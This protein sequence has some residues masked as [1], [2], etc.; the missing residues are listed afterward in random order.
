MK[1]VEDVHLPVDLTNNSLSA[2]KIQQFSILR[3]ISVINTKIFRTTPNVKVI[4][5]AICEN[6]LP[7]SPRQGSTIPHIQYMS[8]SFWHFF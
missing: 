5:N 2:F 4:L 7:K 1:A 8:T 6:G 3:W